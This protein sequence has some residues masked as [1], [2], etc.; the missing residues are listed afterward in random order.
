MTGP[1]QLAC[2]R[3]DALLQ[4]AP[5]PGSWL[6][7][8]ESAR[9]ATLVSTQ[10]RDQFLAARWQARRLLAHVLGGAPQDWPLDA[11]NDAPPRVQGRPGLFLSISH[12]GAYTAC[13][14]AH[15]PVGLDLEAPR[16]RRDIAGLVAL[17]CTPREQALFAG[18]PEAE[19]EALFHELWTVK[20]AWLKQRGEW[21]APSRLQQ[22]EARPEAAGEL[23]AWRAD[24]WRLA[25]TA[26]QV[27]WHTPEPPSARAWCLADLRPA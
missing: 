13:A 14:L 20:E 1:V 17:C 9:L 27:R 11:P 12:S 4:A 5:P 7:A 19:G 18:L 10:R 3:V 2:G 25:V 24:D 8:Q 26:R 15:A 23:R 21:I 6:A 16:R 22:L